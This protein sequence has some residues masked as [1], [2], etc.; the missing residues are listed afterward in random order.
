MGVVTRA[1]AASPALAQTGHGRDHCSADAA[2]AGTRLPEN[3]ASPSAIHDDRGPRAHV[4]GFAQL[5]EH[6]FEATHKYLWNRISN[7]NATCR[8][9]QQR[10]R[11]AQS[12]KRLP[13]ASSEMVPG[14]EWKGKK[15][16]TELPRWTTSHTFV[17]RW[18]GA[19]ALG[20]FAA[21]P[22]GN[23]RS[24]F[25]HGHR[26]CWEAVDSAPGQDF[27][28]R[29]SFPGKPSPPS[30]RHSHSQAAAGGREREVENPRVGVSVSATV[31]H[32]P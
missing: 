22:Q 29:R 20:L 17:S 30:L 27:C 1:A 14:G 19:L 18:L 31:P 7:L 5:S 8:A 15:P 16:D 11:N 25:L 10:C 12:D 3:L 26:T 21:S 23:R 9:R 2:A 4:T 28:G 24:K 6:C 13:R 32:L